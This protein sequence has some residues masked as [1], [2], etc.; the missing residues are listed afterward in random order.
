MKPSR[1]SAEEIRGIRADDREREKRR[2][3]YQEMRRTE[4]AKKY[5]IS[6]ARVSEICN[7]VRYAKYD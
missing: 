3:H 6:P 7:D 2:K 5:R 1:L 4:I